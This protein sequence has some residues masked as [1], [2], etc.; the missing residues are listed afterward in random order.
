MR[1]TDESW[2]SRAVAAFARR[3]GF[4]KGLAGAE[5]V[6]D[7]LFPS[8]ADAVNI[9]GSALH[10][11]EAFGGRAF[12]EK[13]VTFRERLLH[14]KGG[15][16]FQVARRNACAGE[17]SKS[18]SSHPPAARRVGVAFAAELL[19]ERRREKGAMTTRP[20]PGGVAQQRY[21]KSH[22]IFA[23]NLGVKDFRRFRNSQ[24]GACFSRSVL[25]A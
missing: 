4:G 12:A 7:L 11:I 16:R 23:N 3:S 18:P 14:S 17:R 10:D 6:D 24:G 5:D 20:S 19:D 22:R 25:A 13:V 9:D 8:R 1:S 2:I 21:A 15:D